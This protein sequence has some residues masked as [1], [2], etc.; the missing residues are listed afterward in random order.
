MNIHVCNDLERFQLDKSANS[1]DRLHAEKTIYFIKKYETIKILVKDSD[2]SMK[3]KLIDVA[4]ASDF[5]TNLVCLK[6]F[7]Q[8]EIH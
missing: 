5:L 4:L 7:V 1:N 8:K 3:I 2:D 6:K